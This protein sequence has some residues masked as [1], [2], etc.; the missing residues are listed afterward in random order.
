MRRAF[1]IA[2]T[3]WAAK[4]CKQ[5]DLLIAERSNFLAVD[6]DKAKHGGVLDERY[7]QSRSGT[8][9]FDYSATI[10]L[11][12][13]V[14]I[15][16]S[17]VHSVD[18]AFPLDKP[19]RPRAK[20]KDRRV[21]LPVF[22]EREGDAQCGGGLEALAVIGCQRPESGVAQPHR[23]VEHCIEDRGEVTGRGIDDLEDL[24]GRGLTRQRLIALRDTCIEPPLQFSIG[25]PKIGRPFVERRGH[26]LPPP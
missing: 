6:V 7:D 15:G 26:F 21:A 24:G 25:T 18:D 19:R 12:A 1:S 16:I 5:R 23:L 10:G 22:G 17:K 14:G 20:P 9:E 3:A 13:L 8:A 4:F 11:A 2:I